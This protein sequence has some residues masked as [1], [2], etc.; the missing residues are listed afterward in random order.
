M[1]PLIYG[2]LESGDDPPVDFLP[3]DAGRKAAI[4][5]ALGWLVTNGYREV[6]KGGVP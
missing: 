6:P 5:F 3:T 4:A 1:E 2:A